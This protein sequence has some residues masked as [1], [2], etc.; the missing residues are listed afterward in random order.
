LENEK[1]YFQAEFENFKNRESGKAGNNQMQNLILCDLKKWARVEF[2]GESYGY[3]K[4]GLRIRVSGEV[5]E[6]WEF[7]FVDRVGF[8]DMIYFVDRVSCRDMI[9][10]VDRVGFRDRICFVDMVGFRDRICFVDRVDFRDRICFVDRVGFRDRICFV[11]RVSFVGWK[12]MDRIKLNQ[13]KSK[14]A[15]KL[16][17]EHELR[18]ADSKTEL[19]KG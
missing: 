11:D 5:L 6:G 9:Y 15:T 12:R 3:F 2:R 19:C 8:R 16:N 18:T 14:P 17:L 13:N 10:F 4:F 1:S 7:G